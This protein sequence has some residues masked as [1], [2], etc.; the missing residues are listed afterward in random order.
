MSV[1]AFMTPNP[2]VVTMDD[3]LGKL[4]E[5]F[6]S[7]QFHHV[8]VVENNVLMGVVSDRDY[9]KAISPNVGKDIATRKELATLNKRVHQIMSRR[10]VTVCGTDSVQVAVD[11]FREHNVSCLPVLSGQERV[12]GILTWRNLLKA[13]RVKKIHG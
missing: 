1:Q 3:S 5:I 9:L 10:P 11:K 8:L 4:K 7:H 6:D 13:M 2:V 12:I